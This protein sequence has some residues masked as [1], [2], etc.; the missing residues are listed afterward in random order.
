M[1]RSPKGKGT[2]GG[3]RGSAGTAMGRMQA[4][5]PARREDLIFGC[6]L[7]DLF[8]CCAERADE[9]AARTLYFL[10]HCHSD[11]T[12][13][14]GRAWRGPA[15][16]CS[17][18]TAALLVGAHGLAAD[19]V[20]PLPLATPAHTAPTRLWARGADGA[21]RGIDVWL[22]DANHCPGAVLFVFRDG[23]T[24]AVAVHTGDFRYDARAMAVLQCGELQR[25]LR[26]VAC[27]H[28]DTTF[29]DPRYDFPPQADAVHAAADI[30]AR[31]GPH[32]LVLVATYTLGKE[33]V[34]LGIARRCGVRVA[35][36]PARLTRLHMLGLAPADLALFT[37][38]R[39]ATHVHACA[40]GGAPFRALDA[41]LAAAPQYRAAALIQPTGWAQAE[42]A[43]RGVAATVHRHGR[44]TVHGV[45]YSEHC[46]FSELRR[47][48]R[49]LRPRR[50]VPLVVSAQQ[51]AALVLERLLADDGA[52]CTMP[53]PAREAPR[54][55]QQQSL[56]AA[57][58]ASWLSQSHVTSVDT[59][60]TGNAVS[61]VEAVAETAAADGD[62]KERIETET[63]VTAQG[64]WAEGETLVVA[65]TTGFPSTDAEQEETKPEAPHEEKQEEKQE[66]K[67][68][69][70]EEEDDEDADLLIGEFGK[71]HQLLFRRPS[72]PK[73]PRRV[74]STLV[75]FFQPT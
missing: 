55:Q 48:V 45:P 39:A 59:V 62:E 50:I 35:V 2:S 49:L 22:V 34:L 52:P 58:M 25:V 31:A 69:A 63:E 18:V 53:P 26:D 5:V 3:A 41:A 70:Q 20:E 21:A 14:L 64:Q 65:A 66:V 47:F 10:S 1:K 57:A 16:H 7:V 23:A 73:Q 11:H 15:V 9:P 60:G 38:D 12:G 46:S 72:P 61:V 68:G 42:C 19:C 8:R 13:G 44:C 28:L 56:S 51:P 54:K 30:A 37:A 6:V 67:S 74:Q 32:T 4:R 29:C 27:V 33:R 71:E 36:E 17:A 40:L 75:S 24:G 43:A